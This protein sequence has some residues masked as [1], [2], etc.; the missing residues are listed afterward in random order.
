MRKNFEKAEI[1]RARGG[2]RGKLTTLLGNVGIAKTFIQLY[3]LP[4]HRHALPDD[5][6]VVPAW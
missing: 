4:V 1:G 5:V 2:L 6:R 3:L